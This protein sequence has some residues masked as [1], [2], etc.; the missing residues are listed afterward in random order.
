MIIKIFI[1]IFILI[2]LFGFIFTNKFLEIFC[3]ISSLQYR[4]CGLE[5][6]FKIKSTK[7][8]KILCLIAIIVLSYF[9]Y[10]EILNFNN[11][12]T[13]KS[14]DNLIVLKKGGAIETKI[15]KEDADNIYIQNNLSTISKSDIDTI[16][17]INKKDFLDVIFNRNSCYNFKY[18]PEIPDAHIQLMLRT[19]M[20]CPSGYD[21]RS[22]RFIVIKDKK[23]IESLLLP[24]IDGDGVGGEPRLNTNLIFVVCNQKASGISNGYTDSLLASVYLWL[25]AEYLNYAAAIVDILPGPDGNIREKLF[26][27]KLSIPNDVYPFYMILVGYYGNEKRPINKFDISNIHYN[28]WN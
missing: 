1:S 5:A 23:Q 26:R 14:G 25:C 19:A 11:S 16:I 9:L 3:K 7:N 20:C 28:S 6:Q 8:T 13:L 24:I 12:H 22:W 2:F 27:E 18:G 4:T 10:I 15:Y 21:L 17:N